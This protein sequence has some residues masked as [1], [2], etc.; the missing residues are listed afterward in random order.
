MIAYLKHKNIDKKKWDAC[1]EQSASSCI[2]AYS[3]YLD[4]VC[5]NWTALV[6]DDYKAVLPLAPR[7]KYSIHY[8]YQ[9]FFT[10]YF[11]VFS[12]NKSDKTTVNLFLTA[13]P[14]KFKFLEFSLHESTPNEILKKL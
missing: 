12:K 9:P 8:V 4:A 6:L 3:W 11:G 10:R 7:S 5:K 13:I 14:K 2:Y 1:I